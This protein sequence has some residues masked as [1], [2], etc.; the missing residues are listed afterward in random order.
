MTASFTVISH[1]NDL[2]EVRDCSA[3]HLDK[4]WMEAARARRWEFDHLLLD[5]GI[6]VGSIINRLTEINALSS[7]SCSSFV[8]LSIFLREG[9]LFGLIVKTHH[10]GHESFLFLSSRLSGLVLRSSSSCRGLFS[11]GLIEGMDSFVLANGLG[12]LITNVTHDLVVLNGAKVSFMDTD[13]IDIWRVWILDKT[14]A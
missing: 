12:S 11:R 14:V 2:F 10:F 8:T 6:V 7:D 13:A 5:V 3:A 4:T 9:R 1:D